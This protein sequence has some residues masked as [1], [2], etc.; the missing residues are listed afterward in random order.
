MAAKNWTEYTAISPKHYNV[1]NAWLKNFRKLQ[2]DYN[3]S[4]K[5]WVKWYIRNYNSLWNKRHKNPDDVVAILN[6]T[7]VFDEPEVQQSKYTDLKL[8]NVQTAGS[9]VDID[10]TIPEIKHL[11]KALYISA[12]KLGK[13]KPIINSGLRSPK[14]QARAMARNWTKHGGDNGGRRYLMNLYSD[15]VGRAID[16]IFVQNGVDE[17]AIIMASDYIKNN[18]GV[19]AHL[20]GAAIDL[21]LTEGIREVVE[22]AKQSVDFATK[23]LDE[24]DHI[25]IQIS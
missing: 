17:D 4:Y 6:G 3:E 18:G 16:D 8:S 14:S 5:S 23:V 13:P 19:S 20:R 7:Y 24:G 11:I 15:N 12:A 2:G 9:H 1:M 21:K 22:A 10:G 25:H